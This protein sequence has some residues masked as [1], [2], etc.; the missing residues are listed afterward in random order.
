MNEFS[1]I[2]NNSI[3]VTNRF[4][5]SSNDNLQPTDLHSNDEFISS[6]PSLPTSSE[7]TTPHAILT[8]SSGNDRNASTTIANLRDYPSS[9]HTVHL[10]SHTTADTSTGQGTVTTATHGN[11][12]SDEEEIQAATAT[13]PTTP[14][15]RDTTAPPA[16]TNDNTIPD[17]SRQQHQA[18]LPHYAV[19]KSK[20]PAGAKEQAAL[21]E[22]ERQ[23][24]ELRAEEIFE[25]MRIARQVHQAKLQAMVANMQT[26]IQRIW[27]E[28]YIARQKVFNDLMK[29]WE[30]VILD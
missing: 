11:T 7:P 14:Q 26:E 24:D 20:A 30:K 25:Q 23:R 6:S 5:I 29:E 28:V 19:A 1:P 27:N 17:D 18:A 2:T 9:I 3:L 12:Q 21:D 13:I 8:Q 15:E 4:A 22:E 10:N 16:Q